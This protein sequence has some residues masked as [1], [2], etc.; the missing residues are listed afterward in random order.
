[1]YYRVCFRLYGYC[2]SGSG[3]GVR[4]F[5]VAAGALLYFLFFLLCTF[6]L[7]SPSLFYMSIRV[8]YLFLRV[9][10]CVAG[11]V[12]FNFMG[13]TTTIPTIG[14]TSYGFGTRRARGRVMVTSKGKVRVVIFPRLGL[15]KCSYK[16]LFTRDLLL[17][18]TRLTLVR[19]IGGA[20]RLSVVSVINVPI[21][22]GSALVGYTI[23][24]RGNGVLNVIPGA[25]LPGCGRFC[26]G[27]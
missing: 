20:H 17:R 1:M 21:I 12:E 15:A 10:L 5:F 19:V 9:C 11:C 23:I 24:F 13:M 16:S 22:I 4:E 6:S 7:G 18:R 14:M 25:C 8:F 2:G 3:T 26:R 27:H